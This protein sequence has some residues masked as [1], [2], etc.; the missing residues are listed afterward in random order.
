MNDTLE[1]WY[2]LSM[3]DDRLEEMAKEM[4]V[5]PSEILLCDYFQ[6]RLDGTLRNSED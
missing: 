6:W 3:L 4:G 1:D 5:D 2:S